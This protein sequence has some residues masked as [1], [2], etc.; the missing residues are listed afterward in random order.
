[1]PRAELGSNLANPVGCSAQ[2]VFCTQTNPAYHLNRTKKR[3]STV[4][5]PGIAYFCFCIRIFWGYIIINII[6][7]VEFVG[8][9]V[10]VGV[11]GNRH[12]RPR[13][14]HLKP[15]IK[16]TVSRDFELAWTSAGDYNGKRS[17]QDSRIGLL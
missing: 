16:E 15:V 9:S 4:E 10:V 14:E 5:L 11:G 12:P 8:L 6:T 2:V 17:E 1:M 7:N 13:E 3:F